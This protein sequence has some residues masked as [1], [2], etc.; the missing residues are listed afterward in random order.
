MKRHSLTI[1]FMGDT[2]PCVSFTDSNPIEEPPLESEWR[3]TR[4][5]SVV[6]LDNKPKSNLLKSHR[7]SSVANL[8]NK[9]PKLVKKKPVLRKNTSILSFQ[10]I[11]ATSATF[12][13]KLDVTNPVS[14]IALIANQSIWMGTESGSL[15]IWDKVCKNIND[16]I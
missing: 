10:G 8:L 9:D 13:F 15:L 2:T 7:S 16:F 14:Y 3:V 5:C 4:S 11:V 6:E 12:L 1:S